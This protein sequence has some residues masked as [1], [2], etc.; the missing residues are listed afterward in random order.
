MFGALGAWMSASAN[1]SMLRG[2]ADI[3]D[4]NATTAERSAQSALL[5]GQREEQRSSLATANLKGAQITGFAANGVDLG[6]GSAARV[7][8][9]TDILGAIDKNTIAANA[10]RSAWGYRTQATNYQNEAL[11]KRAGAS[12]IS[13]LMAAGTSLL[14]SA[15]S[16]A[17]NWYAMN[18]DGAL[19]NGSAS[20][21]ALRRYGRGDL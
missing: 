6:Q 8:T 20:G 16:V 11:Q 5:A 9:D 7:L 4:I 3:A 2:Q 10:V 12:A 19:G 14:N 17:S 18:K 15:G 21:S 1:Q 13:P